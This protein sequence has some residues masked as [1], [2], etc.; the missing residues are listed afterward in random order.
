MSYWLDVDS[1]SSVYLTDKFKQRLDVYVKFYSIE[2]HLS[3]AKRTTPNPALL[4][5]KGNNH[6]LRQIA[7]LEYA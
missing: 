7:I 4:I 6:S 1:K 3:R 5:V 2:T